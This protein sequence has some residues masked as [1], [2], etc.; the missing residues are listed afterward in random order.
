MLMR[1]LQRSYSKETMDVVMERIRRNG[2]VPQTQIEP[3]QWLFGQAYE[4]WKKYVKEDDAYDDAPD[5]FLG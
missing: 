2:L 1:T 5:E 4:Y 3:L